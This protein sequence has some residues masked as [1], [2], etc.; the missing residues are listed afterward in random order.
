MVL[1][2]DV[3]YVIEHGRDAL[4]HARKNKATITLM[5]SIMALLA[6]T[7]HVV[8]GGLSI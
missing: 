7:K 2:A 5:R 8:G 6:A 1:E 4:L 3:F